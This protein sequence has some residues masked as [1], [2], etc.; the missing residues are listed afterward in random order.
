MTASEGSRPLRVVVAPD[1]FKGSLTAAEAAQALADGFRAAAPYAEVVCHPVADGGEGTVALALAHGFDP[2]TVRVRGPLGEEVEATYAVRGVAAVVEL[3][4]AAGLALL[5]DGP[6]AGTARRAS[7]F[8]VG[9]LLRHALDR[10]ARR[11]ILGVG[12]SATTDGGAGMVEALG[13]RVLDPDGRDVGPGGV[14]L[15]GAASLDVDRLDRRLREVE[16]LVACDVDNPLTGPA[17]AAAVYGPQKGADP[18]LVELL[19]R[20]LGHWADLVAAAVG[21]ELREVPGAGAAGGAAFAGLAVLGGRLAPGIEVFAALGGLADAVAEADLV[22]VGEG[23]LD[24]QSL[25]G[26]GPVGIA[27]LARKHGVPV[28]AAVGRS[29]LDEAQWATAGFDRVHALTDLAARG[30]DSMRDAARLLRAVG[31]RIAEDRPRGDRPHP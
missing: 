22:V 16:L 27:A 25:R 2:V 31:S 9:Q 12:G 19:D 13:G 8:G 28:V 7:T 21:R 18:A 17:G 15:L 10:G 23:S 4:A 29:T 6:G 26:K 5:P 3:A 20:A 24:E 30:A 1:K 11:V 14:A